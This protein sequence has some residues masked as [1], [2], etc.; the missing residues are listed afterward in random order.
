MRIS[1]KPVQ[2]GCALF[3]LLQVGCS[4]LN[5]K[6]VEHTP[7]APGEIVVER[8]RDIPLLDAA[9]WVVGI[10]GKIG[11]WNSRVDN[12]HI[13]DQTEEQLRAY[14]A[15]NGLYH[16][17]AR[18]N[19]YAPLDEWRRLTQNQE[20]GAGWRYTVGA[21]S[22]LGY[23]VLPGRL[24]GGDWYNPYTDSLHVYS[25]VP[26]LAV[27]NAA[28]AAD[29][30][31]REL[32]GTYAFSQ[33]IPGLNMVHD[34]ENTQAALAYIEQTGTLEDRRE[35]HHVLYPRYGLILGDT[36]SDFIIIGKVT[37]ALPLA[38]L[39]GGHV[40]GRFRADRLEDR[41]TASVIPAVGTVDQPTPALAES[42]P[43]SAEMT[44]FRE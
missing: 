33:E 30:R 6:T 31:S 29:V 44:S 42:I 18:L 38:G 11:Y 4:V 41:D 2:L 23:T 1:V 27:V 35:A 34:T 21:I 25:D 36:A 10:P 15:Q 39:L 22:T 12:H 14:M 40:L 13:S 24:L 19:Q 20:V 9:G 5:R 26:S 16:T 43:A 32:P 17:K 8:G 37:G 7:C 3:V 28:Y